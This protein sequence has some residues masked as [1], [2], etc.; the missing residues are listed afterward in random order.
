MDRGDEQFLQ[1]LFPQTL[2]QQISFLLEQN[3]LDDGIFH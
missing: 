3:S 1:E 2:N